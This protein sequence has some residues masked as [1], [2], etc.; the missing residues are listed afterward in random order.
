[1]GGGGETSFDIIVV[2]AGLVGA[3]CALSLASSE[4]SELKIAL[5]E[6]GPETAQ[7]DLTHFD[8][9]VVAIT[10]HSQALFQRLGVWQDMVAQRVSPYQDM[11]VWD[12]EGTGH[13]SFNA[14]QVQQ[15]CLGHIVENS[16]AL[17]AIMNAVEQHAGITIIR[18]ARVKQLVLPSGTQTLVSVILESGDTVQGQLLVAADGANSKLRTLANLPTRE[19]AYGQKAI[20]T[21]VQTA[22]SHQRTAYQRFL[23]SGP[24]AFLPLLDSRGQC[25]SSSIVWSADEAVADSMMALNDEDFCEALGVAFEHRLGEVTQVDKRFCIPLQQRHAI[26]Y[27]TPGMALVGDAAHTLH[28]LAGQ[29]VNLGLLDSEVLASEIIRAHQRSVPLGET[30][31][32]RRYQR[33]RKASNLGMMG[34]M[35]GFKRLFA[36]D[37]LGV[38]YLRN[39]GMK[40]L[41]QLP[42]LKN[43]I[44]RQ[45]MGL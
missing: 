25:T 27:F 35:E 14:Q 6:A 28:P 34:L 13:I 21:S 37:E 16:V 3:T 20:V 43:T 23:S 9:R 32:L 15:A 44:I 22:K 36:S 5:I 33:Q 24:L 17:A 4:N 12:A 18:P 2:G 41:E 7:P 38:R 29:G 31:I 10:P 42:L 19:W 26:D 40:H 45:A 11:Y 1:M 39:A 8:P 30:Q